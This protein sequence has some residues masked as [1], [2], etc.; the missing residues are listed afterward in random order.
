MMAGAD[1]PAT[2]SGLCQPM[3]I[4]M[5]AG[6]GTSVQGRGN[7]SHGP[8][9]SKSGLVGD[10]RRAWFSAQSQSPGIEGPSGAGEG[11][12]GS[13]YASH[14]RGRATRESQRV[15]ELYPGCE[16]VRETGGGEE[17]EERGQ[18]VCSGGEDWVRVRG[19]N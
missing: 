11:R 16:V 6:V 15:C 10:R 17:E 12:R 13:L 5:V 7:A 14:A 1:E 3:A 4:A 8:S 2:L 18:P 9:R 19:M